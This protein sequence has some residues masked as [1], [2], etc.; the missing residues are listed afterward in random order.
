MTNELRASTLPHE[1]V[2]SN[3]FMAGSCLAGGFAS[4]KCR[5]QGPR[6]LLRSA[7]TP[8]DGTFCRL[9][10]R[11]PIGDHAPAVPVTV[12]GRTVMVRAWRYPIRGLRGVVPVYLLDTDLEEN[13]SRDGFMSEAARQR[14]RE[15]SESLCAELRMRS[16]T[17]V[18]FSLGSAG[19]PHSVGRLRASTSRPAE[20][21]R[22]AARR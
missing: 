16:V 22:D 3:D 4:D 8:T 11:I 14:S 15:K 7:T 20:P 6:Q 17:T 10:T 13:L 9:V 19:G 5:F 12:A 1:E 18:Q 21:C 2:A